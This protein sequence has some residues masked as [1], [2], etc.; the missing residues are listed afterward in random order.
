M[1]NDSVAFIAVTGD[2]EQRVRA[3]LNKHDLHLPVYLN[4]G[5]SPNDLPVVGFPTTYI[6]DRQGAAKL[7]SVGPANWD[8]E[9]VR[10]FIRSLATS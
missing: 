2:E 6:L 7:R 1:K 4:K 8:D 10:A 9:G 5:K 3:F